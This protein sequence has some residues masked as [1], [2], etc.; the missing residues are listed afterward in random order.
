MPERGWPRPDGWSECGGGCAVSNVLL[1]VSFLVGVVLTVFIVQ[2]TDPVQVRF[3][4]YDTGGVPL[5][6]VILAS[7]LVGMLIAALVGLR[8]RVHHTLEQRRLT[9]R[10]REL[11]AQLRSSQP[12]PGNTAPPTAGAAE[13]TTPMEPL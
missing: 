5:A 1:V 11:E 3:F 10:I 12:L 7:A 6:A 4:G 13:T 2:N 8:A 9:R